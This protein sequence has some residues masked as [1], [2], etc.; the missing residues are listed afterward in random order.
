MLAFTVR[1]CR[2]SSI[3]SSI[4]VN[5]P[6]FAFGNGMANSR[7][8]LSNAKRT[9][10]LEWRAV[11]FVR[12]YS[13]QMRQMGAM[14]ADRSSLVQDNC[15]PGELGVFAPADFTSEQ[16]HGNHG[17]PKQ[18]AAIFPSFR[19]LRVPYPGGF[20]RP[21]SVAPLQETAVSDGELS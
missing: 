5:R 21:H 10:S 4:S 14:R 6:H 7:A 15:R 2:I 1:W 11:E 20:L 18:T 3:H 8:R 13:F 19:R 17:E 9:A 16:K 12:R